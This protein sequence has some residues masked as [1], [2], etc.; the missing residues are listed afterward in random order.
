MDVS[1]DHMSILMDNKFNQLQEELN[2]N[3]AEQ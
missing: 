2:M 1:H 3:K